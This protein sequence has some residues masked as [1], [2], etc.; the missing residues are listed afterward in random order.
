MFFHKYCIRCDIKIG[1][2]LD[3]E[4][5]GIVESVKS[6]R[7]WLIV[8]L[9]SIGDDLNSVRVCKVGKNK[10]VEEMFDILLKGMPSKYKARGGVNCY[11]YKSNDEKKVYTVRGGKDETGM[12]YPV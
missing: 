12:L 10:S 7:K 2:N 5:V 3:F 6:L 1:W 9:S 11:F 4:N 8:S